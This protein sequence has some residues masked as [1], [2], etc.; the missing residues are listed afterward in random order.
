MIGVSVRHEYPGETGAV[1]VKMVIDRREMPRLADAC[2]DERGIPVRSDEQVCIVALPGHR[3]G[4]V[5]GELDGVERH[6][7]I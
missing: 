5:R 7:N 1:L 3:A 6:R 2:I 4:V